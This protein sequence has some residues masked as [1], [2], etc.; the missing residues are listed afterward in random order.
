[1]RLDS[2]TSSKRSSNWLLL[3]RVKSHLVRSCKSDS[4]ILL[5]ETSGKLYCV[6]FLVEKGV[7]FFHL[8]LEGVPHLQELFPRW[9][10]IIDHEA[11]GHGMMRRLT[12]KICIWVYWSLPSRWGFQEHPAQAYWHWR[13]TCR[14]LRVGNSDCQDLRGTTRATQWWLNERD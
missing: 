13:K 12:W 10:L 9:S 1:M 2:L 5:L 7:A 14:S 6:L 11:D 3:M 4:L 8:F